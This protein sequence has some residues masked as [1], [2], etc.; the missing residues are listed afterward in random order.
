MRLSAELGA[1]VSSASIARHLGQF[2]K[3]KSG[4]NKAGIELERLG[5]AELAVMVDVYG[6]AL[7]KLNLTFG[8]SQPRQAEKEEV[9]KVR[10]I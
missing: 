3:K 5:K 10:K 7:E 6:K 9:K 2:D 1:A 8:M 4:R